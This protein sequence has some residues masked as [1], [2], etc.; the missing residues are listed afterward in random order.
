MV[1][2]KV[3]RSCKMFIEGNECPTCKTTSFIDTWKGRLYIT[4]AAQSEI[5]QK[6]NHTKSGEYAIKVQ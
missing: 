2:R 4:D 6:V 3:C 1:K 5:A